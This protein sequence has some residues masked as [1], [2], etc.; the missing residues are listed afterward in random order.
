MSLPRTFQFS[1]TSL[2]DYVDCSRRFQLRYILQVAWPAPRT[3]PIG[4]QERHRRLARDFHWL[5]H[6]HLLGIPIETLS[7]SIHDPDLERWWGA[8]LAYVSAMGDARVMP[9]LGL[10]IPLAGYRVMAQYD[11]IAVRDRGL[12]QEGAAVDMTSGRP[13]S[14]I[15]VDWK[16]YRQRPSRTWLARRLQTRVYPMV[17]VHATSTLTDW[18]PLGNVDRPIEPAD[19]EMCYWLAEYPDTPEYFSYDA[20]TYQNDLDYIAGLITEIVNRCSSRPGTD[21]VAAATTKDIWPLTAE[22]R[23]CVYC[24]Y[25]SLCERG[26]VGGS[27]EEYMG[28]D[29]EDYLTNGETGL[30]S[31][32][33][34]G[35]VQEIAY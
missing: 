9:E 28:D 35:Q 31:D 15:V 12:T 8:Y 10:S 20:A 26:S 24:N 17:L 34:W 2:Q 21:P 33:D 19:V 16:T 3:E 11:A 18:P 13:P 6:Q 30:D 29:D 1:A 5:A 22:V 7:A 32:L 27:S 4:E 25:R 14:V 23:H